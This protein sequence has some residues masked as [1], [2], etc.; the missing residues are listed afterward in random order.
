MMNKKVSVVIP[1][2]RRANLLRN[3]ILSLT[4]QE[5]NREDFEIIV[6]SDGPDNDTRKMLN[7]IHAPLPFVQLI[8]LSENRGP[9]AARNAGWRAAN[10]VMVAFTDDDC[11]PTENWISNIWNQFIASGEPKY[12]A[13]TGKVN[14]PLPEEPTDY[15][16]NTAHLETADFVTANCAC[17]LAALQLIDGFDER[18]KLA[19]REDS[20]LEFRLI[21]NNVPICR[22]IDAVVIHPVRK[23]KWG[24]SI[25]EQRKTMFNALLYKK[26]PALYR[27]KIQSAPA[28]NYY[29]TIAAILTVITGLLV[30]SKVL[31]WTGSLVYLACTVRFIIRRLK[32]TSRSSNH[33]LEMIT[34]SLVI[35]FLSI[36]WTIYGS[37]K[38]RVLYY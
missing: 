21:E 29:L 32:T 7:D 6:V 34:T 14:V 35:P 24:V 9:A 38:Y 22:K 36:Y 8:A 30:S 27:K 37:V 3:C 12:I 1:T 25:R 10:G 31:L 5:F 19:W 33:I 15:E 11:L 13:F 23:A 17:T 16:R 28:W 2:Y 4:K 26:F 18:F 20:D